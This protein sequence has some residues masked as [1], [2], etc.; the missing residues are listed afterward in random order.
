MAYKQSNNPVSRKTSPL[1]DKGNHPHS[2]DGAH[3]SFALS[4]LDAVTEKEAA[5]SKAQAS[6]LYNPEGQGGTNYESED[7]QTYPGG[8]VGADYDEEGLKKKPV[9]GLKGA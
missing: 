3:T 2:K 9:G 4:E 6:K 5:R 7:E 8:E 1:R